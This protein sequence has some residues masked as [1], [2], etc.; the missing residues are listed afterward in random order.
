V[1]AGI[2]E[3]FLWVRSALLVLTAAFSLWSLVV[4]YSRTV[5]DCSDLHFRWSQ[6][7]NDYEALWHDMYSPRATEI[8]DALRRREAELSKTAASFPNRASRMLKW[9][10]HVLEQHATEALA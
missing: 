5:T 10:T 1:L 8:L 6:L 3:R 9:K 7:A 4:N 2:P